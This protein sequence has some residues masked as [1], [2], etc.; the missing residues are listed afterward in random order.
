MVAKIPGVKSIAADMEKGTLTVVGEVDVV[1]VVY[2]LRKAKFNAHVITVGDDKMEERSKIPPA[3]NKGEPLKIPP[4]KKEEP[5]KFQ[6]D[7]SDGYQETSSMDLL[8]LPWNSVSLGA[9]VSIFRKLAGTGHKTE[10]KKLTTRLLKLSRTQDPPVT[11]RIWMKDVRE[12]SYDM[13]NCVAAEEDWIGKLSGFMDRMREANGRYDTYKLGSVPSRRMDI[14]SIPAVVRGQKPADPVVGLHAKGGAVETL[15]NLLTDGDE[16]L[17]VL[18]IVGVAG[19]GKTTLAKQLWRERMFQGFDCR[20]FVRMAKKPDMRRILRSLL[21]QVRPHQPPDASDVHDLIHD[22]TEHLQNKRYFLI[23]DDLWATSVWDVATCAFPEGNHGSRIITTTEI[24]DVALAS[25]SY[26]SKYIFKMEP[27]S[28]SHSKELFTSAVFGSG[29]EKSRELDL[30]SDEIIRRCDG[31]PQAIISISSVLASHGEANT[32]E[33]WEQIQNSLPTNTTSDEIL[34]QVLYFCYDSLPICVQACLLYLGIYPENYIILTEDIAKQ[35]VAEGFISAPTEKLKMIVAHSYFDKLVKMGMIQQIDANYSD[36]VLYYAVHHMVHD[37]IT[38]K[39]KEENFISVIDYSQR[40]VRFSNK[41]SRM[42]LQFG[43]ATYATTPPSIGL[44]Q[45][46]SLAYTGLTSCLPPNYISEFKLLRVLILHIWADQPSTGVALECISALLLLRYLQATCNCTVHLPEQMQRLKHLETLEI[47]ARVEAIPSD[48][49][50]LQSLLHLRLGGGTQLPYVT[51]ILKNVT[52]NPAIS[53]DESSSPPDTVMTIEILIPIFR[54]P[55]R[56]G[57]LT[58]LRSLK[59]VVRELLRSDI[60]NLQGLPSLTVLSLHVLRQTTELIG[61]ASGVFRAL[62]YFE[63]RCGVL[64]LIFQE[65]TMPNLQRLTLGFNAHRGEQYGA[66]LLGIEDMLSVQKIYGM[67]GSATGAEERDLKAAESAFKKAMGKHP[68]VRVKRIDVVDEEYGPSEK[69]QTETTQ[70]EDAPSHVSSEQPAIP[71]QESKEDAKQNDPYSIQR[72]TN[73]KDVA[74]V[75]QGYSDNLEL[76]S[77]ARGEVNLMEEER[78]N[79]LGRGNSS[80]VFTLNL[81]ETITND[82]SDDQRVGSGGHG[83]VYKAIYKGLEIAVK[84][85]RPL[86]GLDDKQFQ[87]ELYDLT[88]V[89]HQNIVRLIG[90]CYESRHK[91]IKHNGETI[92]AKSMERVLCFE[93]IQGE[94]LEKH[95]A[96]G[97]CELGWPMC[98][99]II[100]GTCEGLNHLH[101]APDKPILHLNLKPANIL[102]DKSMMP[103]IADLGLSRVFASSE[104]HQTEIVNGTNEY[105]PPEYLDDRFISKKFDVFSFGVIILKM[106]AGNTGYFHCSDMSPKE[107]IKIVSEKWTKRLQAMPGSYSSHEVDIIRVT[108]CV[109]IALRCVDNDRDKRPRIKDIVHELEELEV[110]IEKMSIHELHNLTLQENLETQTREVEEKR[111]RKELMMAENCFGEV[112]DNYKLNKMTRYMGKPKTQEDRAREALNQVN[113]DDKEGKASSYVDDLKRMHGGLVS[114]SCLVYNATGDTLYQVDYHDWHGHIG[115]PPCPAR[116]GNGQWAAF[117]H[118]KAACETSGSAAAVVY[119]SKNRDGQDREYLVAWSTPWGP[120]SST[121]KAYCEIGGVDSF[122]NSWDSIY[123]KMSNSG[124]SAKAT[125]DGCDIEVKIGGGASAPFISRITMR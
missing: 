66:S 109:E 33:N 21:A 120:F 10:I 69:E 55:K 72:R 92:W 4:A 86:Q 43:S 37:F 80:M 35:W 50:H 20:A 25:C 118:V 23:I 64:R 51:G 108:T 122:K 81:I 38:S 9:M 19:I 119:R 63:F 61:F 93:Y 89:C 73:R 65:G 101:S 39:C 8:L 71:K 88:K 29:K 31:L 79:S 91:Y 105:M 90:Y 54:T 70:E 44:S 7:P 26:Q 123:H 22:L 78:K 117:H 106:V 62:V 6:P 60:S 114:T 52:L 48:I 57:Q 34:K 115:S 40:T 84:K 99:N 113:E 107:F 11:A 124:F 1:C 42:S 47:N 74:N 53:M 77:G 85:L 46:R 32:V 125:S 83:D 75:A 96:D 5:K 41:V 17:K 49:V 36:E 3:R 27:L 95:I 97:S 94:S 67:I 59:I 45:V 68:N 12:L 121:N 14:V 104:T 100:R 110:E 28:V 56:I 58:K 18:S 103:K 30:V 76:V 15:C 116:I 102:L 24:E 112:V 98:Y 82:F 2:A 13:D 87:N 111:V 16:Q